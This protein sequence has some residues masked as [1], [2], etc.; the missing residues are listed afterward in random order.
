MTLSNDATLFCFNKISLA[1]V[2]PASLKK[3][4]DKLECLKRMLTI[5]G[6]TRGMS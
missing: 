4:I 2:G 1:R 5:W 3:D 6:V